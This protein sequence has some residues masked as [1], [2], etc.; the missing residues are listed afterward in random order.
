MKYDNEK[1]TQTTQHQVHKLI[2]NITSK[3]HYIVN[4]FAEVTHYLKVE[5]SHQILN[6]NVCYLQP[7]QIVSFLQEIP[8][9]SYK[10]VRAYILL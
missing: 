8:T 2:R 1:K 6:S 4:V 5:N 9:I 3:I 7:N 10:N